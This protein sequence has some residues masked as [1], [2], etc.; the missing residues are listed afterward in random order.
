MAESSLARIVVR[1]AA[2]LVYIG[3]A[4]T[5]MVASAVGAAFRCDDNCLAPEYW[6]GWQ[7]DPNAWQWEWIVPLAA[8]GAVLAAA[9]VI[10]SWFHRSIGIGLLGF[11]AALF[12]AN[13]AFW[14]SG[15]TES[16]Q[17]FVSVLVVPAL[18]VAV[19]G[20]VAVGLRARSRY[21]SPRYRD[22]A[23]NQ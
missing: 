20:M 11:H 12:V 3:G 7:D 14:I 15:D 8:A 10:A 18:V 16:R 2:A 1:V 6:H 17:E 9:A 21:A 22:H 13:V 23:V 19:G 4:V 5:W